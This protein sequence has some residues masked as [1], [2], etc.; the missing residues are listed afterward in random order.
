MVPFKDIINKYMYNNKLDTDHIIH[1]TEL[2]VTNDEPIYDIL[3]DSSISPEEVAIKALTKCLQVKGN[4]TSLRVEDVISGLHSMNIDYKEFL[5]PVVNYI[6]ELRS[7]YES[8]NKMQESVDFDDVVVDAVNKVKED[9]IRDGIVSEDEFIL[10]CYDKYRDLT[11]ILNIPKD[12]KS[13]IKDYGK[14]VYRDLIDQDLKEG[15]SGVNLLNPS[16]YLEIPTEFEIDNTDLQKPEDLVGKY[17]KIGRNYHQ[18][19]SVKPTSNNMFIVDFA[20]GTDKSIGGEFEPATFDEIK[21]LNTYKEVTPKQE[22]FLGPSDKVI[23]DS[24]SKGLYTESTDTEYKIGDRVKYD[25]NIMGVNPKIG[26]GEIIGV[27]NGIAT[28]GYTKPNKVYKIKGDNGVTFSLDSTAILEKL[29]DKKTEVVNSDGQVVPE[30]ED[31]LETL[32]TRKE[33]IERLIDKYTV[34]KDERKINALKKDLENVKR[35][36]WNYSNPD[37]PMKMDGD[38]V[39]ESIQTSSETMNKLKTL[40]PKNT[41]IANITIDEDKDNLVVKDLTTNKEIAKINKSNINVN[42]LHELNLLKS[43]TKKQESIDE[44]NYYVKVFKDGVGEIDYREFTDEQEAIKFAEQTKQEGNRGVVYNMYNNEA[45]YDYNP[46]KTESKDMLESHSVVNDKNIDAIKDKFTPPASKNKDVK[47]EAHS[48]TVEQI[49]FQEIIEMMEEAEDYEELYSAAQLIANNDLKNEVLDAI[50]VCEDDNDDVDV[51][52]SV[53][54]SDLLDSLAMSGYK[55]IENYLNSLDESCKKEAVQS[56]KS[57]MDTVQDYMDRLKTAVDKQDWKQVKDIKSEVFKDDTLEIMQKINI[58]TKVHEM[59]KNMNAPKEAINT[60]YDL[61]EA[62]NLIWS[63]HYT[64]TDEEL[65]DAYNE[66]TLDEEDPEDF[67]EWKQ[68]YQPD[69]D[70]V[71]DQLMYEFTDIVFPMIQNQCNHDTLILGGAIQ[72]FNGKFNSGKIISANQ[73]DL[74]DIL[75]DYDEVNFFD[76]DEGIKIE[77]IHHDGNDYFSLYT[78]PEN[79][80][81]ISTALGYEDEVKENNDEETIN[82]YGLDNLANDE[83]SEDLANGYIDVMELLQHSDKLVPIKNVLATKN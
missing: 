44:S 82:N 64:P 70:S 69:Y 35:E 20:A 6:K 73:D 78:L 55:N 49:S 26:T 59:L 71:D 46:N 38:T 47:K 61:D 33:A 32:K 53:V 77:A 42:D 8:E 34:L 41:D 15:Y 72:K 7:D 40:L 60:I 37:K 21:K 62:K 1:E 19:L 23:N 52:Y 10:Q 9:N 65:Q 48:N 63:D 81:D 16:S 79:L 13:F 22:R 36:I 18:V 4:T 24:K 67:E 51:A 39:E 54:T 50:Q 43:D 57:I 45:I 27:S 30:T 2:Y 66:Y 83:F 25:G 56:D 11:D 3:I 75:S 80:T 76:T 17:I 5:Q 29:E 68:S 58:Y 74:M 12:I 31:I 28:H 14:S